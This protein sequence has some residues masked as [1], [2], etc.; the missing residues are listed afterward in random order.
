[1]DPRHRQQR[2]LQH[3]FLVVGRATE[4]DA[5]RAARGGNRVLGVDGDRGAAPRQHRREH[6]QCV[7]ATLLGEARVRPQLGLQRGVAVGGGE[8]EAQRVGDQQGDEAVAPRSGLRRGACGQ[9]EPVKREV[10]RV[11][12]AIVPLVERGREE[13]REP[14]VRVRRTPGQRRA[15]GGERREQLARCEVLAGAPQLGHHL[16]VGER[17]GLRAPAPGGDPANR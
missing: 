14:P 3:P 16:V 13:A 17:C 15:G 2:Q 8:L 12:V 1:M 6:E 9:L 4:H 5:Q 10:A 11:V 7:A